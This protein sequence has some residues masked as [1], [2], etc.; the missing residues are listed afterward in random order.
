MNLLH[1]LQHNKCVVVEECSSSFLPCLKD[2]EFCVWDKINRPAGMTKIAYF[3]RNP[4]L[5]IIQWEQFFQENSEA[6][7]VS[8]ISISITVTWIEKQRFLNTKHTIPFHT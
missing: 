7:V 4:P 3:R 5:R 1:M 2:T 6:E 8:I